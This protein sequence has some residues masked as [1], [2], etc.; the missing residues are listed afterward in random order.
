M[1]SKVNAGGYK[2]PTGEPFAQAIPDG[3]QPDLLVT[4]QIVRTGTGTDTVPGADQF[5]IYDANGF[6]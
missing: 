5:L 6:K 1:D 2:G 4:Y 3:E